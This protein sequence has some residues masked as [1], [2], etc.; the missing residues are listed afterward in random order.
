MIADYFTN[1]FQRNLFK[2]FCDLIMEY[3]H[4]GYIL[5][6]I[7]STENEHI[8]NK[9]KV[10]DNSNLKKMTINKQFDYRYEIMT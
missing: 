6:D 10:I 9:N 1:P 3:K 2:L 4:T 7:K 5:E 8:G